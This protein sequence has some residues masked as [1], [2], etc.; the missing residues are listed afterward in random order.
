MFTKFVL[1]PTMQDWEKVVEPAQR[2]AARVTVGPHLMNL[3]DTFEIPV[4]F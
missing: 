4:E 1:T 3:K 2:G